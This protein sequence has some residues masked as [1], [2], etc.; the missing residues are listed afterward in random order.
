MLNTVNQVYPDIL[1][2][3]AVKCYNNFVKMLLL[4]SILFKP[5][6]ILVV[7]WFLGNLQQTPAEEHVK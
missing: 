1:H 2:T 4:K 5:H 7:D 3:I 6:K